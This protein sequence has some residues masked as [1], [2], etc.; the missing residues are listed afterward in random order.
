MRILGVDT[1]TSQS[2]IA[3]L[4][5]GNLRAEAAF[6]PQGLGRTSVTTAK[7]SHSEAVLPLIESVLERAHRRV[8][9][10]DAIGVSIG[11]GSF[12]GLRIGLALV[13]GIAYENDVPVVG[14][15]SLEARAARVTDFCGA[16]CPLIDARKQEVYAALFARRTGELVRHRDDQAVEISGLVSLFATIADGTA[17]AFVG[18]GAQ[19]YRE[20]L[21]HLFD[22]QAQII[23]EDCGT[24]AAVAVARLALARLGDAPGNDLGQLVPL[25]LGSSQALGHSR[26][27]LPNQLK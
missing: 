20:Q 6:P 4:E 26:R 22:G 18:N 16:I 5:D 15:S 21:L 11:P 17:I 10:I 24:S 25:Y 1:A 9:D 13:K 27:I 14:V 23:S 19:R 8:S 12:T 7:S 2:S 3:F